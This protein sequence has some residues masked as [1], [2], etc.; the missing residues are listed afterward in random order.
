[1]THRITRVAAVLT[2][3]LGAATAARA[4][5]TT[6]RATRDS[7]PPI[8]RELRAVWIATVDNMDWPSRGGL[9]AEEQQR[10]L[11]AILDKCVQ[12][13]MNAIVLQVRPAADALYR[14]EIEPWSE[15]LSGEMGRAPEPYYDP[16]AFA[17]AEAHKS[18]LELHAWINPYRARYSMTRPASANHV[19][20]TNPE[21]VRKYGSYLWMDPGDPRVRDRTTR[22]VLDIV[23]RYDIDALHMDDYFYPYK[24][25]QRGRE[26]P[27]PDDATYARYRRGGGTMT[28][29]D[30]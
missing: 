25:S 26:I 7:I 18:G 17:I 21:L 5:T 24:E 9:P 2:L 12:L 22:V 20:R 3:L 23:R 14:S 16:L 13:R 28:R 4:Q 15:V 27:F 10:E 29:E 1:M 19:S 8:P 6:A 30:W 11:L